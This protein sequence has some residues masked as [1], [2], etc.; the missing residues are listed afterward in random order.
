VIHARDDSGRL[1]TLAPYVRILT[2]IPAVPV[3][4]LRDAAA[5]PAGVMRVE[6]DRSTDLRTV[7][8]T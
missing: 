2:A 6:R 3:F 8:G 1:T 5:P 7:R 4:R